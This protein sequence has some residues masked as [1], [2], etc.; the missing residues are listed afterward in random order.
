MVLSSVFLIAISSS[1]VV[2]LIQE[3]I[4]HFFSKSRC[5]IKFE[6]GEKSEENIMSDRNTL[7]NDINFT[8]QRLS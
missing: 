6:V 3:G 8:N 5:K 4:K 1:V 2:S 7:K